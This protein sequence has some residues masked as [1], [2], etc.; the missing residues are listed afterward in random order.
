MTQMTKKEQHPELVSAEP[1]PL[2]KKTI[3]SGKLFRLI[4]TRNSRHNWIDE[5]YEETPA[6]ADY[7][8]FH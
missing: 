1:E 7:Q 6:R 5:L 3:A 8:T 2:A 4:V